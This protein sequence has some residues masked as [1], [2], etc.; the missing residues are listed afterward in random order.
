MGKTTLRPGGFGW[1][2]PFLVVR[3]PAKSLA[4]YQEA[5]GFGP[6]DVMT[7]D[8]GAITHADLRWQDQIILMLSPEYP[9]GSRVAPITSGAKPSS[10]LSVYAPDIDALCERA[11]G[12][13][14]TVLAEP[15]DM[16]WGDRLTTLVDLDGYH[17]NFATYIGFA[18][19]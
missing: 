10:I 9:D 7:D 5:F 6:G 1:L 17:W 11:R 15:A 16:P 2:T 3:D 4:F 8:T 12:A 13:G 19:G 18:E 14:A